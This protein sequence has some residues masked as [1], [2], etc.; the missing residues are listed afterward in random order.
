MGVPTLN[1]FTCDYASGY[2]AGDGYVSK[3]GNQYT[4]QYTAM[5]YSSQTTCRIS[6]RDSNGLAKFAITIPASGSC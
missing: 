1:S 4:Y 3:T 2:A 5:S 6:I